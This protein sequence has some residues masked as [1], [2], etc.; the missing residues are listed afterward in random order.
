[1][2]NKTLLIVLGAVVILIIALLAVSMNYTSKLTGDKIAIIRIHGTISSRE[3]FMQPDQ[4]NPTTIIGLLKK[5]EEDSSI[6]AIVLEINS[7]GG[8]AV[9]S[10][11]IAA[12]IKSIEKPTVAWIGD[13]GASGAYWVASAADKV[14]A[15]PL[16][17][18]CN[19]GAY[20]L[21]PDLS[22]FFEEY[23]LNFTIIKSGELKDAGSIYRPMTDEEKEL[24]QNM[25]DTVQEVF[26]NEVAENRNLT[27]HQISQISDA[28]VCI[29]R[30]AL[31]FGLVDELGNEETAVA[32]AQELAGMTTSKTIVIKE[33][34]SNLFE[35]II[36]TK[37]TE[38][39]YAMGVGLGREITSGPETSILNS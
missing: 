11:E 16:S 28:R 38:A 24:F 21:M 23:G 29:G 33:T 37:L 18:T 26:L 1:M 8:S 7:G 39:F 9:A 22:G 20:S 17:L 12:K 19:I 30:D 34:S 10:D 13:V 35:E 31:E 2:A 15:H 5:A 27:P 25:V 36:G 4:S 3:I 6:K 14:V 32:L